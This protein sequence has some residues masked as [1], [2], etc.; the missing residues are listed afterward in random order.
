M[1]SIAYRLADYPVLS[2]LAQ[3]QTAAKRLD[4]RACRYLY[5][6]NNVDVSTLSEAEKVFF[7]YL[8]KR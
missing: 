6:S 4:A 5:A 8:F 7:K 2:Q 1:E 3:K